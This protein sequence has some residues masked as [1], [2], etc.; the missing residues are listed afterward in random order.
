MYLGGTSTAV[1]L[2]KGKFY[3]LLLILHLTNLKSSSNFI[4][5]EG[6]SLLIEVS[7][8][9]FIL[10]AIRMKFILEA[11]RM[12]SKILESTTRCVPVNLSIPNHRP[13]EKNHSVQRHKR[14]SHMDPQR[15]AWIL[16]TTDVESQ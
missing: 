12:N 2:G 6:S 1:S 3:V 14:V 8:L 7:S 10:E 5:I 15:I 4:L 13:Y 11:I 16:E 9:E